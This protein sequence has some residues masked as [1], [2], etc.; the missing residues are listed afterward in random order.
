MFVLLYGST[1]QS[2]SQ[3]PQEVLKTAAVNF[4]IVQGLIHERWY[5]QYVPPV[6]IS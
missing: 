5:Y 1:L 4:L 2:L 3:Q 6:G